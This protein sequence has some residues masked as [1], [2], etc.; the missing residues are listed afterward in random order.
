VANMNI[1]LINNILIKSIEHSNLAHT[2]SNVDGD[3]EL[4]YVNQ[5]FLDDTG[6]EREDVIGRNCRFLQ[7]ENTNKDT[8]QEIK[9]A[10]GLFESLDVEILNYRKDGSPFWNRLRVAPVY[11]ED[12]N[13]V[14]FIGI[15]SDITYI[16]KAQRH[17]QERQKLEAL[18]R[19]TGNISHEIKNALQ[20]IK[21]MSEIMQNWKKLE[22][23]KIERCIEI[24][25]EN[26]QIAD[27]ITQDVLRFSRKSHA[28][29]EK[30]NVL[31]LKDD[32]SRF[33][34]NLLHGQVR[35]DQKIETTENEPVYVY[36]SLNH[37]YQI[38]INLVNNAL[39]AMKG[40]GKL[41]LHWSFKNLDNLNALALGISSGAY[42]CIGIE[43]TGCGMDKKTLV[44]AFDPF[45][46][47]KPP[48]EG[49]GLGLSISYRIINDWFGIITAVSEKNKGSTFTMY[50]PVA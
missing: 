25:N 3:M 16:R 41:T 40:N 12:K 37:L 6:Y 39:Y 46:S 15:Q 45:Y 11:D 28:D 36:I 8:V 20:P 47:T 4:M 23:G 43:D 14:A 10:L 32:V 26:V 33:V 5:A 7:G 17:E 31:E 2:I 27:K 9:R 49:T 13:P 50:I 18:G 21:L 24:L 44:S 38:I 19:M 35:Y 22:E 34:Q 1:D 42:L 48:G 29:L 30:I